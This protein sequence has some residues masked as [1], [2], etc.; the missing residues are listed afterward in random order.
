MTF[1]DVVNRFHSIKA[2]RL[3]MSFSVDSLGNKCIYF[4]Q[5]SYTKCLTL[6]NILNMLNKTYGKR[7]LTEIEQATAVSLLLTR[8]ERDTLEQSKKIE[9]YRWF[10]V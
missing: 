6:N 2:D 10:K 9:F 5:N 3:N 8:I 1:E 7:E 4:N